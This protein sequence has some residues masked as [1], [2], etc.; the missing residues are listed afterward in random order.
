[1]SSCGSRPSDHVFLPQQKPIILQYKAL[2]ILQPEQSSLS[3][4]FAKFLSVVAKRP[5]FKHGPWGQ[6]WLRA[7]SDA[8][9]SGRQYLDATPNCI[10]PP[11]YLLPPFRHTITRRNPS[12]IISINPHNQTATPIPP[13]SIYDTLKRATTNHRSAP[14]QR[15]QPSTMFFFFTCGTHGT[16]T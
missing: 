12:R 1:L 7:G 13:A 2:T 15:T 14:P 5:Q 10:T 6:V 11:A 3:M 8:R 16:L 4:H 9:L